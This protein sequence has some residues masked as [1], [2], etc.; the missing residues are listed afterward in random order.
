MQEPAPEA[1]PSTLNLPSILFAIFRHKVLIALCTVAGLVGAGYVALT[2]QVMYQSRAKLLVRYVVERSTVDP[3]EHTGRGT[4]TALGSEAEILSSWDLAVQVAEAL[5]PERLLPGEGKT[6]TKEAAAAAVSRGLSINVGRGSNIIGITYTNPRP[7]LTTLVLNELVNRYFVKHLEVHRS[8]GAFDFVS[9]QA[10]QVRARLNQTEDALKNLKAKIHIASLPESM[11]AVTAELIRIE[12]QLRGA[13]AEVAEQRARVKAL[14]LAAVGSH[15]SSGT[16]SADGSSTQTGQSSPG[17][18]LTI[19]PSQPSPADAERYS[20]LAARALQLRQ[21]ELVLLSKYTPENNLVKLNA[22]EARDIERQLLDLRTRYPAL[23]GMTE[24]T[25]RPDLFAE[26][27]RLAGVEAKSRMLQTRL[28]EVRERF[29]ELSDAGPQVAEL[30]RKKEMEE[31]TYKYFQQTLEK[32]RI[33]EALDP[34]KIPNISAVQRPSPPGMVTGKRNKMML[35]FAGAGIA[36]GLALAVLHDLV[37][38]RTVKRP[39]DL[40]A[41]LRIPPLI[42]I[43]YSS[44]GRRTARLKH[45]GGGGPSSNGQL[46]RNVAPWDEGHFIRPFAEAIR[47]RIGLY[48]ELNQLTHKP[49]LLGVTS[50]SDGAGTSTLAAGLAAALSEVGDGKVLLVDVRLGPEDVHPFFKGRPALGLPDAL[51]AAETR[52]PAADNLY[53]ATVGTNGAGL[54]QLG[55]KKFFEMVPNLKASDFDYIVF[56]MPPLSQTS[57]TIGMAGFMDKILLVVEAEENN[58]ET[59]RRGYTALASERNN[60]SVVLNKAR[61]Y[62]P[63]WLDGET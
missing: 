35:T 24:A 50:F 39:F 19:D 1:E 43:P 42:T 29:K 9:Q 40:E 27:A 61:S 5:G 48:F 45:S 62:V 10:D 25:Q 28:Q 14:E 46:A 6:A 13:E 53:L 56:D 17:N 41:Q 60:V 22:A 36:L 4:D 58:R 37:L 23:S 18:P 34:S 54:A 11:S 44:N 55:L 57:P 30:E 12:E 3:M 63:K 7:E 26:R 51:A 52:E 16:A 49:K 2:Y 15:G 31:A 59:V 32:A 21:A 38:N 20:T 47:D 8:A 33:D